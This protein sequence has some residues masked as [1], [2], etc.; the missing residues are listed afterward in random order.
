[1]EL[2]LKFKPKPN[3]NPKQ[4]DGVDS[5]LNITKKFVNDLSICKSF[6]GEH[7]NKV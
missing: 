5:Q 3:P 7:P 1:M 6:I 2:N 4:L